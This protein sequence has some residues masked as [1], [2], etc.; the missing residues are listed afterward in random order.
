MSRA[1]ALA[2]SLW[3]LNAVIFFMADVEGGLGPFL[4]VYLQKQHWT[5]AQIGVGPRLG[6]ADFLNGTGHVNAGLGAVMTMQGA[7][8]SLSPAFA[9]L[10]AGRLGYSASFLSLGA[11]ACLALVLW[12]VAR[13]LTADARQGRPAGATRRMRPAALS[14]SR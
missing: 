11:I 3:A 5:P 13:P 9:G 7:G 6:G 8:A 1:A 4:G 14:V 2:S 12:V 10:V